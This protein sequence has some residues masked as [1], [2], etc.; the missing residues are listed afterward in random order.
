M[1]EIKFL[2]GSG[3]SESGGFQQS[4]LAN[5]SRT[6]KW[7]VQPSWFEEWRQSIGKKS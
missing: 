7:P 5:R 4:F 6:N 2:I 3:D 1:K